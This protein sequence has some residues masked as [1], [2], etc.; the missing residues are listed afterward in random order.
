MKK[1][2]FVFIGIVLGTS[3]F[4][5]TKRIAHY[6]HSGSSA[7]FRIDGDGSY[8]EVDPSY[9]YRW[10][11]ALD[12]MNRADSTRR[13][14]SLRIDSTLH[15]KT[16]QRQQQAGIGGGGQVVSKVGR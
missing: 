5:Q 13:A 2:L 8:G 4:A 9:Y 7:T 11:F 16:P 6:S 14:D 12:S 1:I 3:A 10:K 15:P